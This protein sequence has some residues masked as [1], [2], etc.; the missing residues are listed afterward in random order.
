MNFEL[1]IVFKDLNNRRKIFSKILLSQSLKII[2]HFKEL[3]FS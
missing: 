1:M 2:N 3:K